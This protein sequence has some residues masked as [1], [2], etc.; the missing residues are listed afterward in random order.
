MNEFFKTGIH[1]LLHRG[2]HEVIHYAGHELPKA[3]DE[4][5]KK[6][7][8][9][10]KQR[11]VPFWTKEEQER[12]TQKLLEQKRLL[13]ESLEEHRLFQEKQEKQ[14]LREERLEQEHLERV[15]LFQEKQEKQRLERKKLV[16]SLLCIASVFFIFGCWYYQNNKKSYIQSHPAPAIHP[17]P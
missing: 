5:N 17:Y 2:L 9:T 12:S 13:Q 10:P 4:I 6:L 3:I 11:E 15:R 7:T 16:V 1:F 8:E 14:R